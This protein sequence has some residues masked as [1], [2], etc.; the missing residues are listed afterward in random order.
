[1]AGET[2]GLRRFRFHPL[3]LLPLLPSL[4]S[5]RTSDLHV[6]SGLVL[7]ILLWGG[8]NVALKQIVGS[9]PPFWTGSTRFLIA[10]LLLLSL[11][12]WS[13]IWGPWRTPG[14][15]LNRALWWRAGLSLAVYIAACN[16][17]LRFIPASHFALDMA[18]APVWALLTEPGRVDGR[19]RFQRWLAAALAFAG[20]AV[21]IGPSLRGGGHLL[22]ELMG[23]GT[24]VLW[25]WHSRQCKAVGAGLSG[26]AVTAHAMWRAGW[27]LVPL[28]AL[29]LLLLR[30]L[31]PF[32]PRLLGLHA[33]CITLGGV[34][35]FSLWNFALGHWPVSRVALFGNLIPVSTMAWAW[36]TL[37][38]PFSP[39]FGLALLL[40]L[41][42]V[43]LGQAQL[44]AFLRRPPPVE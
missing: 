4:V 15:E 12:R 3:P 29:E 25:T 37:G 30:Q 2:H 40:I 23:L 10:G 35:P 1:M 33:Y 9:W 22:G 38:E 31:P 26:A 34:V 13:G 24:A 44:P 7:G 6:G 43:V 39:T 36:F 27:L 41:G 18:T 21:L 5:A 42:G 20:V 14:P 19:K 8:N 16:W 17:T 28:A 11:V 32:T